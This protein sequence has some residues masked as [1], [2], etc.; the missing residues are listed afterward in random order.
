[1]A[2]DISKEIL[3]L[4]QH[5]ELGQY[6][7]TALQRI[8]DGLNALGDHIGAD[9]TGT[10][11]AP[12]P[13]QALDVKAKDGLI[14]ATVSDNNPIQKNLHW[15]VEYD[16]DPNFTKPH[17]AHLGVSRSMRPVTLPAKDDNGNDQKFYFRAYSQYPGSHP[18]EPI[19]YG[20]TTPTAVDPGGS[21][22]MSLL[23]STGSGTA[24]SSGEQGGA[25]FG[26]V[27][28]RPGTTPKR[29]S[30]QT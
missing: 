14:Q 27:L 28:K 21:I 2:L 7:G 20:G 11:P 1:M 13:V 6:L 23:P 4:K 12:P 24:Q 16:T 18:S 8:Q 10:M 30:A 29:T 17:V 25:G 15:F 5:P 9:P 3:Y 22:Q 19:H 26:K